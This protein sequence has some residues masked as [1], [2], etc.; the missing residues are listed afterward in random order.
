MNRIALL[1]SGQGSQYVG[2]G[3]AWYDSFLEAD[4]IF[5]EAADIL[6]YDLK[7]LCMKGPISQLSKTFYT[8]PAILTISI[9]A[10]R[11]YMHEVGIVP[12]FSAGHSLGEYS[13]LVSSGVLSFG[14]ALRLVQERGRIMEEASKADLGCMVA[15]RGADLHLLEELCEHFT[16]NSQPVTIACY[17]STYQYV[18][19][20]HHAS[21]AAVA[22]QLEQQGGQITHL[23]VSG[24]FHSPLMQQAADLLALELQK[25]TF[26]EPL[27]PIIS[28][29]TALPY[30]DVNSIR[31]GLYLQMIR[32]VRWVQTMKYMEK[33][34]VK[35]GIELG[36]RTVLKNLAKETKAAFEVLSLDRNLD[37]IALQHRFSL[38]DWVK[39]VLAQAISTPNTNW[40]EDEYQRGVIL[41]VRRLEELLKS[42]ELGSSSS[43]YE[44][45]HEALECIR[46]I[47]QTK[48][49]TAR[50]KEEVLDLLRRDQDGAISD[51]N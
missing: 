26:S 30:T 44:Q 48:Q 33:H 34:G 8:Q 7:T 21:V 4:R 20:G 27:W 47:L 43:A 25:Y 22:R 3:A 6:G 35:Q 24:P 17:N 42:I 29:V 15:V 18:I 16:V 37:R 50:E 10:F 40:N 46:L 51:F 28:N 2:M 45:R 1:F 41:P 12:E 39:T 11:L 19:S 5:E 9:I 13:S 31:Q 38:R 36:P 23:Q 14:D 49:V 32:P